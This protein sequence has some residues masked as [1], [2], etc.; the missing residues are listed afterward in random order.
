MFLILQCELL[1]NSGWP[2]CYTEKSKDGKI[3]Q[4]G[5]IHAFDGTAYWK[6]NFVDCKNFHDTNLNLDMTV[7][8]CY[9]D[10]CNVK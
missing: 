4:R 7:C 2:I 6:P 8:L 3:V 10:N 5:I 1:V 9:T